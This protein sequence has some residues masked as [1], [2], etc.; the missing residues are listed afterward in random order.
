LVRLGSLQAVQQTSMVMNAVSCRRGDSFGR[1]GGPRGEGFTLIE[2]LVVIAIIAI[3]AALLLPALAKAKEKAVKIQCTSNLKQ[4]GLAVTMYGG[5]NREYFPA[6]PTSDGASGF[7]WTAVGLNTN[8]Y[9]QYLYPNRP[10]V[11]TQE[12]NKQ[13]VLYCPTDQWH[14]AVESELDKINLIGYQFLPGRDA[15]GWPDYN[16]QGLGEWVFR[17][18]LGGPYRKAP[19]MIDKMQA[20]G[21]V[22]NLTWSGSTGVTSQN[23]PFANHL[24]STGI[25]IGG[26]FLYEDGSVLW[27]KFDLARLKTAIDVGCGSGGW[28]V[29]YRPGD[30]NAGP[31]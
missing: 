4:W 23:F 21:T 17:T 29:F 31:W 5:D 19:V 14:R 3:L 20:T 28:S 27:R 30:L 26:N 6:N 13:D 9:P 1:N 12:R 8:F 11:N 24:N 15:N 25:P 16:D 22:P 7:A 2:L 18:K 10:G